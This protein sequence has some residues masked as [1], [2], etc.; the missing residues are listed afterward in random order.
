MRAELASMLGVA[1]SLLITDVWAGP[2]VTV[3]NTASNPVPVSV[4]GSTSIS[5]TVNA[6]QNGTW[7]VGITGNTPGTPLFVVISATNP[8]QTKMSTDP[9]HGELQFQVPANKRLVIEYVSYICQYSAAALPSIGAVGLATTV[10]GVHATHWIPHDSSEGQNVGV[11][12]R[13]VTGRQTRIYADPS[14]SVSLQTFGDIGQ[15]EISIS[16]SLIDV[17]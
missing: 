4:Q 11:T 6:A 9:Q 3:T 15:P 10:N 2:N 13:C 7:N 8:F 14:T 12:H 17:Q 1:F 16:G 5:G